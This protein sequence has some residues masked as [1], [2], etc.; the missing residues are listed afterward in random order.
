MDSRLFHVFLVINSLFDWTLDF[1]QHGPKRIQDNK[2]KDNI[3]SGSQKRTGAELNIM[4]L[5]HYFSSLIL[6]KGVCNH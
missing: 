1:W 2:S 3:K 5:I 4:S 6:Y